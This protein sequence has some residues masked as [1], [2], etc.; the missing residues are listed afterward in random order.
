MKRRLGNVLFFVL[1]LFHA[2]GPSFGQ[3]GAGSLPEQEK[4]AAPANASLDFRLPLSPQPATDAGLFDES[5][6]FLPN[7]SFNQR[8]P[9]LADLF[10]NGASNLCFPT[11]LAE[12]MAY[13]FGYHNP[14]YANLALA[15]LSAD[16]FT[17][18][19]NALIRDLSSACHTNPDSG[20]D[21]L[22]AVHCARDLL[23]KSGYSVSST[24]LISPF[25]LNAGP[26]VVNREVTLQDIRAALKAGSPVI[27]E[28]A[29]FAYDAVA[30]KWTRDGGHYFGVYGY[31]Y[32]LA[33]G[34]NE[35]QLK[36]VNPDLVYDGARRFALFDTI[37][38]ERY[39]AQPGVAY[40]PNRPFILSGNGFGGV[41]KRAFLGMMLAVSP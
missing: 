2:C 21:G 39:S 20:T 25:H 12:N 28:V 31:D 40:P 33:W 26:E 3:T 8:D 29:W 19:P 4:A 32:D 34:E 27:L 22:D 9:A 35:I 15:G 41:S 17:L 23:G 13:L 24:L 11:A 6:L 7:F 14:R 18:D 1:F 36:V 30:K 10:A 37:T 16:G 38:L 5:V